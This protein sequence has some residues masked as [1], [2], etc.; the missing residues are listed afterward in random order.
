MAANDGEIHIEHT[1]PDGRKFLAHQTSHNKASMVTNKEA[2]LRLHLLP[3]SGKRRLD[4]IDVLWVVR[5]FTA[6]C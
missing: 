5:G 3:A 6:G 1:W 4:Q 2:I